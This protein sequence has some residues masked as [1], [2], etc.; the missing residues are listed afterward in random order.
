MKNLFLVAFFCSIF[1]ASFTSAIAQPSLKFINGVNF[2][3]ENISS[4]EL[5]SPALSPASTLFSVSKPIIS[6]ATEKCSKIQFKYALLLNKEVEAIVNL[7]LFGFIEE[8][9]NTKYRYGGTSKKGIDCSAFTGL[10]MS[11]VYAVRMPRTAKQQYAETQRVNKEELTEGDLVFFNT[12]RGV[13]HVGAYLGDGYFVHASS[14]NGVTINNL[15]EEYYSKRYIGAGR[16]NF[17]SDNMSK[18]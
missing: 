1:S 13:S 18:L 14:S 12:K 17:T 6:F 10:L 5:I 15:D 7:N 16:V 3:N 11:C 9:W 8:W 4:P 2:G